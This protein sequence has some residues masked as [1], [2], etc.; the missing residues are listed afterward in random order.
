MRIMHSIMD[1]RD[2]GLEAYFTMD[3]GPQVK[4]L[5]LEKDVE[6]LKKRLSEIEGIEDMHIASPGED[7]KVTEE[8]LF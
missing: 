3:A 5:C 7:A 4:V 6:E 8:H 2:E 1:W